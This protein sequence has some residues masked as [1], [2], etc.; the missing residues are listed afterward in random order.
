MNLY[1]LIAFLSLSTSGGIIQTSE[2]AG[3]Y[4]TKKDFISGSI[5]M[6]NNP[7]L[8]IKSN[9]FRLR[10]P[11]SIDSDESMYL[12]QSDKRET[13]IDPKSVYGFSVNGITFVYNESEKKYLSVLND[14]G[15]I[16]FFLKE[17]TKYLGKLGQHIKDVLLYTTDLDV[18]AKEFTAENIQRDF[19]GNN[20]MVDRLTKLNEDIKK[21]SFQSDVDKQDF[22]E[23]QKLFKKYL[24]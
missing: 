8:R 7:R 20:A 9:P 17:R 2:T 15:G 16:Y 21:S 12:T 14:K 22:F 23:Y 6:F 5:E 10:F 18:P 13:K 3:I 24:D 4:R 19:V 1:I 11:L